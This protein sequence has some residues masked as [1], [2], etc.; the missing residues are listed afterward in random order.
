MTYLVNSMLI[1]F[2]STLQNLCDALK[3][4]E[5]LTIAHL[6]VQLDLKTVLS[7]PVTEP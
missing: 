2:Q 3:E 7:H 6:A 4:N 1:L 5:T